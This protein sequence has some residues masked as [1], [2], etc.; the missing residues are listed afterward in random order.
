MPYL[1]S[2]DEIAA[3]ID[4]G[5]HAVARRSAP[6]RYATLIGLLAV[7]GMRV[8]EAIRLDRGD[9]DLANGLLTVRDGKFGKSRELAAAPQHH[10]GAARYQRRR[11]RLAPR[12]RHAGVV[13][14]HGRHPADL[15]QR[16]PRVPA[17]G[18][19]APGSQPRS[20]SCRPRIA[21]PAA[22]ASP[23]D[24]CST[25]TAAGDDVQARLPLLSTYLGHVAPG[26]HLLV[27]V[28][29]PGAARARR[30]PAR[31]PSDGAAVDERAR[32]DAAG[33]LH[34]PAHRASATPARTPSPPTATRCGCCSASPPSAPASRP[35]TLDIDDLDAPL[36][37]AFLDHLE[38]ERGNSVRTRNARLAAIHSLFRYAALRHPE[39]AAHDRSAC[40]RSRPNA[41]TGR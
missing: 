11:D 25:A 20:A 8:G 14:L 13:R 27:P 2:D 38:H 39:H 40:W 32:P 4:R 37:G 15:L 9:V 33:V 12:D 22:H 28:G 3:L 41:S 29:R 21:R 17:A 24:R 19:A 26:E 18:R 5:R 7:T 30:R 16:A 10:R 23:S 35:S 31:A 34:R 36:I 1:Y 6:R